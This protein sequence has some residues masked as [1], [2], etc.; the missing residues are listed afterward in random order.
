[1]LLFYITF[2]NALFILFLGFPGS[3]F[4]PHPKPDP[5]WDSKPS[6]EAPFSKKTLKYHLL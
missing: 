4:K 3:E 1:M 5:D 2:G 6:T